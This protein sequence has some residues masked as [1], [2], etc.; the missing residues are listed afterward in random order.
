MPMTEVCSPHMFGTVGW[1]FFYA[2]CLKPYLFR[3]DPEE[4]HDR[5]TRLGERMG[6]SRLGR[7]LTR[8]ALRYAHPSL[9]QTILGMRF[10]NPIG[11]AEEKYCYGEKEG[12]KDGRESR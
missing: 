7:C 1:R 9:E 6:H 8:V 4:V 5:M 3:Q 11:L 2:S 10:A 12:E